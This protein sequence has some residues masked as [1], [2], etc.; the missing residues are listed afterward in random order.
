MTRNKD[1]SLAVRGVIANTERTGA[2]STW[3]DRDLGE[4][5]ES[6]HRL[7]REEG[8]VKELEDP[9]NASRRDKIKETQ[10]KERAAD[11]DKMRRDREQKEAESEDRITSIQA[12][13]A[14]ARLRIE[15]KSQ[16]AQLLAFDAAQREKIAKM[17]EAVDHERDPATKGRRQRELDAERDAQG[18]QRAEFVAEQQRRLAA[19]REESS[20]RVAASEAA[21]NESYLRAAQNTYQADEAAFKASWDRKIATL[22]AAVDKEIPGSEKAAER[23]R[24]LD[25]GRGERT[26]AEAEREA[27]QAK[28]TREHAFE[29]S[30]MELRNEGRGGTADL[31][32]IIHRADEALKKEE[33]NPNE[34]GKSCAKKRTGSSAWRGSSWGSKGRPWDRSDRW[35]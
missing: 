2:G 12:Q 14:E 16:E 19:D 8:F 29:N 3:G 30:Q 15:G 33:G 7:R 10:D 13:G 26:A 34:Q 28:R 11:E 22:Q 24:E 25:A 21:A 31:L 6:I 35:T 20:I 23:Q 32:G 18:A 5:D 1:L 17:Q 27:G 9:A 4:G